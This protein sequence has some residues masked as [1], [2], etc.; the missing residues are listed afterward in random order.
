MNNELDWAWNGTVLSYTE[1]IFQ[2]LPG[3]TEE[4]HQ[5]SRLG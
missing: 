3:C 1:I 4:N 2:D 5:K